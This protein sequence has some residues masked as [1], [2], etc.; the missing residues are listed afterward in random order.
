MLALP[1]DLEDRGTAIDKSRFFFQGNV[2]D[3]VPLED[4]AQ[5]QDHGPLAILPGGKGVG[6]V[7]AWSPSLGASR[8]SLS[9][10]TPGS[11]TRRERRLDGL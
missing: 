5:R 6:Y 1:I 9:T 7:A 8:H 3:G 2:I 11:S 4:Q 10:P